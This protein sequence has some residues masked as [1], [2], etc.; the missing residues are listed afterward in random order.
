VAA[1][2][3]LAILAGLGA[4]ALV[5]WS[6]RA[7]PAPIAAGVLAAAAVLQF[8]WVYLPVV[9]SRSDTASAPRADVEFARSF[10]ATLPADAY[11]LT[12][13]PGMFHVWGVNAGQMSLAAAPAAVD[14]LGARFAGGVYLHWNY[15][16]NTDD[17]VHRRLCVKVRELMPIVK[18]GEQRFDDQMFAFYRMQLT[19]RTRRTP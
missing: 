10:A 16:C 15:W 7:A 11:V 14:A 18:V 17:A 5:R 9:R 1:Y 8:V 2:P 3:P 13:N 19:Q 6:S 4:G 12:H